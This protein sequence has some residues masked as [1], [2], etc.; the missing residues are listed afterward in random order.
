MVPGLVGLRAH[1][2]LLHQEF[3]CLDS[4]LIWIIQD[5]VQYCKFSSCLTIVPGSTI[6]ASY[7]QATAIHRTEHVHICKPR[8]AC[9]CKL[10]F[11]SGLNSATSGQNYSNDSKVCS[12]MHPDLQS[13]NHA[14]TLLLLPF[15][16]A[17]TVH[18]S[19][20]Q[21]R[22]GGNSPWLYSSYALSL[23]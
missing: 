6:D 9:D 1:G 11:L 16:K 14:T 19:E 3:L 15:L 18:A 22:R 12:S 4:T 10:M 8:S 2:V 23:H 20:L 7:C 21:G 5:G 13:T 17:Q